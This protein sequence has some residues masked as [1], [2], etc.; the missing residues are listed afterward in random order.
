MLAIASSPASRPNLQL[1]DL[2]YQTLAW[3]Q[4]Y[5]QNPS[6][7]LRNRIA[8]KNIG[9]VEK[10]ARRVSHVAPMNFDELVA[11][12]SKGL[13]KAVERFDVSRGFQFSS[14][15][16]LHIYGAIMHEL[17]DY[18]AD[19]IKIR[20]QSREKIALCKRMER[21]LG[22]KPSR[23]ALAKA[24]NVTTEEL[25]L[26]ERETSRISVASIYADDEQWDFPAPEPE[27]DE[28]LEWMHNAIARIPDKALRRVMALVAQGAE[29]GAIAR[30]LH[31]S[32]ETVTSLTEQ[33]VQLL[34]DKARNE[35]H[36]D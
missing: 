3:L 22:R 5:S 34:R 15:A 32:L 25:E 9:L 23:S 18:S 6:E 33:G 2:K 13:V 8:E 29:A 36:D 20:R 26:I 12:G 31:L 14:F 4:E 17:R 28:Q 21:K 16:M 30:H 1:V 27:H 35:L 10:V 11:C 24:I 19:L 7:E